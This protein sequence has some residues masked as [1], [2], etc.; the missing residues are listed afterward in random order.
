MPKYAT[1]NAARAVEPMAATAPATIDLVA[2]EAARARGA[3]PSGVVLGIRDTPRIS[4][5]IP[6]LNE[7]ANLPHVFQHL[8]ADLFEVLLVDGGSVDDTV[9]V[10]RR[11]RPDVRVIRQNRMGKGNALAC[12]FSAARGDIIVMLDADGSADP[13]EIPAFVAA[14]CRGAHYAKGTRFGPGGGS[15]DITTFR[16][17]GNRWLNRLSNRLHGT[18]FTDLCYGY[19]AFWRVCTPYL[20][21]S[22]PVIEVD[23]AQDGSVPDVDPTVRLRWGDGFEIET[24]INVRV[25]AARM[26]IAEVASFE[27]SR[28]HGRSNLHAMRDGFR[29]LRTIAMERRRLA[30]VTGTDPSL[31]KP[32]ESFGLPHVPAIPLPTFA[33]GEAT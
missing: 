2:L 31:P 28:L 22:E 13:R 27:S 6:T 15:D 20:E 9:A 25:F 18:S 30:H 14:L 3:E 7:A 32:W 29:V 17:W 11:L 24:L 21:L 10:A 5:V 23:E 16:A 19:N 4:V 33:A 26:A 12:G 8:P 1:S